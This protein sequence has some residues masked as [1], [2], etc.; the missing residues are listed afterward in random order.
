[1]KARGCHAPCGATGTDRPRPT[2]K[3]YEHFSPTSWT[4]NA[5]KARAQISAQK[6]A[7][8]LALDVLGK[9]LFLAVGGWFAHAW[10][11]LDGAILDL[12]LEPKRFRRYLKK[13][14]AT[15]GEIARNVVGQGCFAPVNLEENARVEDVQPIA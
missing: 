14:T 1:M 12:T 9:R 4:S 11:L 2:R 5:R 13:Y 6:E 7:S 10:L 3:S 8:E 15:V